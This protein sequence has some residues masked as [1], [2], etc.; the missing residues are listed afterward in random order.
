MNNRHLY[1]DGR[2]DYVARFFK[3][4]IAVNRN[5]Y[6]LG[7]L[8][9]LSIFC[10]PLLEALDPYQ[11]HT[12]CM[13]KATLMHKREKQHTGSPL[14]TGQ[15]Q[16]LYC[17]FCGEMQVWPR[18]ISRSCTDRAL[19]VSTLHEISRWHYCLQYLPSITWKLLQ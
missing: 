16:E 14:L 13:E 15:L 10:Q 11:L 1:F 2:S 12:V 4:W 18:P 19:W 3:I 5:R 7:L 8:K 17:G 6:T 9:Y